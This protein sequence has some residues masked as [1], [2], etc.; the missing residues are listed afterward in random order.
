[1]GHVSRLCLPWDPTHRFLGNNGNEC[2]SWNAIQYIIKEAN[3]TSTFDVVQVMQAL[4]LRERDKKLYTFD[5][6]STALNSKLSD[7]EKS[8]FIRR[9]FPWMLDLVKIGPTTLIDVPLLRSGTN[10]EVLL[11]HKQVA[12]LLVC[13]FFSL[14]MYPKQFSDRFWCLDRKKRFPSPNMCQML[15]A[16][17]TPSQVS[18]AYALV[19][20]FATIFEKD[21]EYL[22]GHYLSFTRK[23]CP[24]I[25]SFETSVVPLQPISLT[26]GLIEDNTEA[27]QVI[28]ANKLIG[29]GVLRKGCV[30]EEIRLIVS[31]ELLAALTFSEELG[32]D[33]ALFC[34]GAL[35]YVSYTGYS[36]TFCVQGKCSKQVRET[37]FPGCEKK[38]I[39]SS[40][41]WMD[42]VCFRQME[43]DAQY[44]QSFI[45]REMKK[46]YICFGGSSRWASLRP[47]APVA[48]GNWGCG[49]FCGDPQLKLLIQWCAASE[50]GH[51]ISYSVFDQTLEGFD[52][53]VRKVAQERWTVGDLY[54]RL[55]CYQT[56]R[57]NFEGLFSFLLNNSC[58]K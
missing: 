11:S 43:K 12:T 14:F 55:M 47:K 39:E 56:Q 8:H 26:N 52:S 25:P 24:D 35:Q 30:Q 29:G 34:D 32:D 21:D 28:F 46:A 2:Q 57:E 48:T 9:V 4:L 15:S 20:Y 7:H 33:E 40:V 19:L 41:V 53:L 45:R 10:A 1:M 58:G 38:I 36:K 31:T 16:R 22:N 42:A 50:C 6:L 18:K 27:L 37:S 5:S 23:F 17:A 54:K 44:A 13:S 51:P 49:A 3:P